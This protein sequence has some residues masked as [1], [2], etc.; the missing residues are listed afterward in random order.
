[1]I[2]KFKEIFSYRE[3]LYNLTVKELK[4]KYKNSVL[5]FL[6]SFFNPLM[7]LIV[8]TLLLNM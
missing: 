4:L 6:W 8:Y 7:M 5:G 2:E 3:L 1:M